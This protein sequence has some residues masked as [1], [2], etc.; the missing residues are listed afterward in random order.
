MA[1]CGFDLATQHIQRRF[2]RRSLRSGFRFCAVANPGPR[3]DLPNPE[4]L[5]RA[6]MPSQPRVRRDHPVEPGA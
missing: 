1:G 4:A 3:R 6:A 2:L 5:A